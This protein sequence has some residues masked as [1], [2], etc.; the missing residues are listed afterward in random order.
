MNFTNLSRYSRLNEKTYR[1]HFQKG[2]C[3]EPLNSA[4]MEEVFSPQGSQLL[5]VDCTFVAKSGLHTDGLGSFYN[6]SKGQSERGLEWSVIAVVD[7]D[8]QTGYPLSAQQTEPSQA[9]HAKTASTPNTATS[10][11]D[12]YL[13]HLA[14]SPPYWPASVRY[15]VGDAFYSKRK[16][17]TGVTGLGL[18]AIGKLRCDANLKYRYNG[19]QKSKGRPKQYQGKV[20][21]TDTSRLRWIKDVGNHM[22]LYT[23]DVYC[24]AFKCDIRLVY[25]L[26][27]K[28]G[29]TSYV[30][31]FSTD[32]TIDPYDLY[33]FYKARFHIEFIFRDAKQFTGLCDCQGRSYQTLDSH[34]NA[35]LTALNLAKVDLLKR[36]KTDTPVS[37]SIASYKRLALNEHLLER[38]ICMFE[39]DPTLIKSHPNYEAIRSYGLIAA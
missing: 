4:L 3:F 26:K 24:V 10:R 38:F 33:R 34:F 32:L 28:A 2:F 5:A 37:F 17:V 16:W 11:V 23:A 14:L 31:L 9:A 22:K 15:I 19:P 13:G 12:L 20:D 39:L 8:Q 1:R 30:L 25:L 29:K 18:Q 27:E 35:S 36:Q 6:G 7:V 21:F